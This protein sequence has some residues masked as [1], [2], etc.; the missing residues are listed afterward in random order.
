M[1]LSAFIRHANLISPRTVLL[2]PLSP[3]F[4][5]FCNIIG[6]LDMD[7]YDLIQNITHSL[8]QF[9]ASPYIA[10]L[11][12]LL[13]TLQSLCMPLVQAK[14]RL[15]PQ[16]KLASL[17]PA[18]GTRRDQLAMR[19]QLMPQDPTYPNA[20]P[21]EDS[22]NHLQQ[23]QTP[24]ESYRDEEMMWQLFNSQLS[25]EWFESEPFSFQGYT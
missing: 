2:Y 22:V 5:L 10:K 12:K 14:E 21:F 16:A 23:L 19:D 6:E 1:L 15:G 4:V 13:D 24:E 3:F 7:D 8:S 11:L 20:S 18:M 9:T 17:Y 25:L